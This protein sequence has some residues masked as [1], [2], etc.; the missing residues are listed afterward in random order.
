M[1]ALRAVTHP[2]KIKSQPQSVRSIKLEDRGQLVVTTRRIDG[3]WI[4]ISRYGDD[5]WWLTGSPTNVTNSVT[6]LDFGQIPTRFREVVKGMMYRYRMRGRPGRKRPGPSTMINLLKNMTTFFNYVERLNVQKLSTVSPLLCANYAEYCKI[7]PGKIS[8]KPISAAHLC[9]RLTAVEIIHELSQS[10]DQPLPQHPWED[11]SAGEI[12]GY[13]KARRLTGNTTP[14]L[15]DELFSALFQKAWAIVEAADEILDLRDAVLNLDPPPAAT[16]A[17]YVQSL[18]WT[19]LKSLGWLENTSKFISDLVD[20]RTACYIVIASLSGCR[21]H[22]ISFLRSKS[23]YST[24]DDEGERYWWMRSKSTKTDEG[25]TEWMIPD[26]AVTALKVMDRW[27]APAQ[28]MLR[29][30]IDAYR[31]NDP[32]DPRIG[33]AQEHLDAVFVGTDKA[34]DSQV[35][36]VSGKRMNVLLRKFC[37]SCAPKWQLASHQF[38]RK[39]A[40]Y[41]AR[42]KFGDLRYLK[43]HFKHWTLDMTLG[44]ALNES[45]E[46]ALYLEVEDELDQLKEGRVDYWLKKGTPLTGGYG[47]SLMNWRAREENVTLFKDHAHMVRSVAESTAIRS[48]GHAWCTSDDRQ[49]PGNDLDPT[50]CAGDAT[51][52]SGCK[53][54]VVDEVHAPI[55]I[56]LYRNLE[57]VQRSSD[58]GAGGQQRV[59]RDLRR[60]RSV[61]EELG[62]SQ[63]AGES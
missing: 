62:M 17:K 24:E 1:T 54:A 63:L 7:T 61:L 56:A 20:I 11:S 34:K 21:N 57:E 25:F 51:Q 42:S 45:Q 4:V 52:G 15:S 44:Y 37:R 41:A 47:K 27:A 55:Y 38:R 33:V 53:S 19:H 2:S 43:E 5:V 30:Q 12:S 46:M 28:A 59:A 50:R 8:G 32:N 58:I 49:C 36:T 23:Y 31:E 39:F 3:E 10:T 29:A 6:K 14:L 22:E 13:G 16:N 26:A 9:A 40:N 35:R 48:N 60:C 18:K